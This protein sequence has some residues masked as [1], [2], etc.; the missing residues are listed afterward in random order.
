LISA[1][2]IADAL[3]AF[4]AGKGRQL[5]LSALQNGVVKCILRLA[6]RQPVRAPGSSCVLG[7]KMAQL[8]SIRFSL[9]ILRK[10]AKLA[11]I[12]VFSLAIGLAAASAGLSTFH[13]LLLRP[14]AV[15][16]P[17][18]LLTLYTVTPNEPFSQV[19]YPDYRYYRDNNSVFSG[20]CAIPFSIG[21]QTIIFEKR[22]K[23]GLIN[24]VSDNYFSVLGVQPFLGRWF[25]GDDDK[26]T[27]SAVLSYG[28]WQWLGADPNII[29]KTLKIN[30]VPLTIVGVAPRRFVGTIL[31]DVPDLWHPLSATPAISHQTYDWLADRTSH[32][33]SLIGRMKPGVTRQQALAEMQRLSRQ[34]A[35]AYPETNKNRLAALTETSMLPP[36]AMSSAKLMGGLM[37]AVVALVLFAA[38]AN[39]ANLLLALAGARRQEILIRAALGATRMSLVR[40]LLVDSLVISVMGGMVGF[41]FASYGLRRLIDFKPFM[42]GIG[43]IPITL[44][45]RPDLTVVSVMV[46]VVFLVGLSTGLL[47][48]LHASTPNLAAALNGEVVIGGT[49]KGRIRSFLVVL[50]VTAC[51]VVLIGV[52]LCLKSLHNLQQVK[53]GYSARN[54]VL[55]AIDDLRVNGYSEQQGRA[56]FERLREDVGQLPGIESFSLGDTIPFSGGINTDQVHITGVP[57]DNEHGV[58]IGSGVVDDGY[59][60]TLG[61]PILAGRTFAASD[62]AK[63]PEVIV[64]NQTMA[65]KYWPNQNPVGKTLHIENGTRQATVVGVVG[66]LKYSDIDEVPQPFMYYCL[67]QKYQSGMYLVV[68]TKGNPSQRMGTILEN[69]R[70]ST[71]E[72]G[73]VSFT[74][75]QWH[76]FALYVPHLAVICTSAF[77]LLAF[78]LAAVGLYGAV[79]YSVS[80]RTREMGIRVAFGA[81]PRDLWKLILHQT[82]A[83]TIIGIFLG[84][85]GGIG[86]SLL[87]RSLLYQ[88]QPIEWFAFLGAAFTMLA[89]TVVIAYSAAHPWMQVDPMQSLRHV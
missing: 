13:A 34:L 28:Y 42:P 67:T 39:V 60:S 71:P 23:S 9:R 8:P 45:F 54:V 89:M 74:I 53:L 72:L 22:E 51:T 70:K 31:S 5:N 84:I 12:A 11:C 69:V 63:S 20:L 14:P 1:V 64:V 58:T 61:I 19:S 44:D 79:F 18:R 32:T 88:I 40:Q 78:V 55:Y 15:A 43:V 81:S 82:S 46:A 76:E 36:D 50:Q 30:G 37:L 38:C 75:E 16:D 26:V 56:L 62:T 27:T 7:G 80:E 83:V 10:H 6:L 49:R 87:A 35:V 85:A 52:G 4:Q 57:D 29:G 47:P 66:D 2:N 68:R 59:F 24:A 33:L 17:N 73:V 41:V 77:G 65:A 21:L 48:G 25:A 86:A 3:D